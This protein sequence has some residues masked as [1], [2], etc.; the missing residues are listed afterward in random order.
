M[1]SVPTTELTSFGLPRA[2]CRPDAN[3]TAI[4][5]ALVRPALPRHHLCFG[6]DVAHAP[7]EYPSARSQELAPRTTNATLLAALGD[8]SAVDCN[9][10]PLPKREFQ[11]NTKS[12]GAPRALLLSLSVSLRAV[13]AC[14]FSLRRSE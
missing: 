10:P 11:C 4:L 13:L 2:V 9:Y 8:K 7:H 5:R 12:I 14:L 1:C 6:A 3:L